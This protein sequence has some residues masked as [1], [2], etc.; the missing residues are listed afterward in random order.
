M[1]TSTSYTYHDDYY[2]INTGA[3][4]KGGLELDVP[5]LTHHLALWHPRQPTS[6]GAERSVTRY[7]RLVD[8]YVAAHYAALRA[9]ANFEC[10]FEFDVD[11]TDV[12]CLFGG[13]Y[14]AA[15]PHDLE[16]FEIEAKAEHFIL[17][18]AMKLFT[19]NDPR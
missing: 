7:G 10:N 18:D 17:K 16:P 5:A 6:S 12:V 4:R 19:A 14:R 3:H 1:T 13:A 11:D 2:S 15:S 9:L 8:A